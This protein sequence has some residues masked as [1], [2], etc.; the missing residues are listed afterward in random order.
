MHFVTPEVDGGPVVIQA[1]I[2]INDDDDAVSLA[3]RVLQQEHR[4]YPLA[5]RW[6]AE[7]RLTY[8]DNRAMLDGKPLETR[9]IHYQHPAEHYVL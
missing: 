7:G 3:A 1:S 9:G 4:I 5:I 8:A 6:F 2:D